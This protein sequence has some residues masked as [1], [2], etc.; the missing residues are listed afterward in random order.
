[1]ISK[2]E[3]FKK[4]SGMYKMAVNDEEWTQIFCKITSIKM[5]ATL[6]TVKTYIFGKLFAWNFTYNARL[7][8][9]HVRA[10]Y[11]TKPRQGY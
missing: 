10:D 6:E 11:P 8:P 5:I 3:E 1:M 7:I 9:F 2:I 4:V